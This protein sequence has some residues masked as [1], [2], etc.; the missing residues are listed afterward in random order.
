MAPKTNRPLTGLNPRFQPSCWMTLWAKVFCQL[1]QR[2]AG[3]PEK[4]NPPNLN[5]GRLSFLQ[6][7]CIGVSDRPGQKIPSSTSLISGHRISAPTQSQILC[8]F[9]VFCKV[10]LQIEPTIN[11]FEEFFYINRQIEFADGH[12]LELSGVSIQRRRAVPSSSHST[13][14]S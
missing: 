13:K 6:I 1:K 7:F 14:S 8:L 9:Q 2:S 5:R 3:A 4:E 10:Y 12:S 11:L